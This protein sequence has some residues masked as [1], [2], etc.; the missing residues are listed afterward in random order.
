[1]EDPVF[2]FSPLGTGHGSLYTRPRAAKFYFTKDTSVKTKVKSQVIILRI[3]L[4]SE[5]WDDSGKVSS[6]LKTILITDV[7]NLRFL[8]LRG[9]GKSSLI[10]PTPTKYIFCFEVSKRIPPAVITPACMIATERPKYESTAYLHCS[11]RHTPMFVSLADYWCHSS[12]SKPTFMWRFRIV[13]PILTNA[14]ATSNF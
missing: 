14:S 10:Q 3:S 12:P 13:A 5:S 4:K 6:G 8:E 9:R 7:A 1:M 11:R 2:L